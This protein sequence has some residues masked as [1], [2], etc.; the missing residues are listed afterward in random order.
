MLALRAA[1]RSSRS[2]VV[3]GSADWLAR[4]Q[5]DD[6]GFSF[7]TRGGGSF[8][9]ETGAALQGARRR[10]AAAERERRRARSP[11]LR[12][13]QNTGRRLRAVRG[14]PLQRPVDRLGDPG[15]RRRRR[16]RPRASGRRG[17]SPLAFLASLQQADGSYRYSR[18]S[19]QTP[20]WVTAQAIAAVR[21]KPLPLRPGRAAGAAGALCTPSRLRAPYPRTLQREAEAC[22]AGGRADARPPGPRAA[23][24]IAARPRLP[25]PSARAGLARAAR[26]AAPARRTRRRRRCSPTAAGI[27][28]SGERHV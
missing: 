26:C 9:D 1:G 23:R 21:R 27:A 3:K 24:P 22:T 25:A 14:L 5:N 10:R 18:S 11:I 12:K 20:V 17:R 7:A 6:G 8:V 2:S 19:A 15:H 13:A 4:Q 16:E 28:R